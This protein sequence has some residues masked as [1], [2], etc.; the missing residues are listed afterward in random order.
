MIY[1]GDL[2][3]L[4]NKYDMAIDRIRTF[5][6]AEG[7]YLAF[8]GGKDSQAV[9]HLAQEAGVMFDAHYHLTTVDPPELVRFIRANYPDV[10]IEKP[11]AT[12][13]ELIVKCKMPPTRTV[14]YCCDILKEGGG[15]GRTV[16]TGVRR[17]ESQRRRDRP[18]MTL[19]LGRKSEIRLNSDND[20][21]RRMFETC[22][23]KGKN[24]LNPVVDW[25]EAEVW[26][27]LNGNSI[28]HCSL[29]D[30]GF[31]R[32]GCIGCPLAGQNHMLM[33]FERWP[34]YY[35]AYLRAFDRMLMA[36]REAGM[37][38]G[39]WT[40]AQDVMDWWTS[41]DRNPTVDLSNLSTLDDFM[42]VFS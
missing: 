38:N 32:L 15:K 3:G 23:K 25:T 6:P 31:T 9:Y 21:V 40:S 2:F 13:W 41:A 39:K 37:D 11:K 5:E 24:V 16:I 14:R 35:D 7:Y 36:R 33:E 1:G 4:R 18:I 26:E 42:E 8:S 17:A 34:K 12:M 20:E 27:Y 30:E 19:N 28:Q 22:Q 29:Y 10:T